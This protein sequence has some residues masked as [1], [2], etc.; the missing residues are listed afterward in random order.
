M[1]PFFFGDSA[2]PLFGVYHPP[3]GPRPRRSGVVV[4]NPFGQEY[5][6]AHR[7]L[8]QLA[9]RLA[10]EGFHA[11]RFDYFACGDSAGDDLAGGLERWTEDAAV[12]L[13]EMEAHSGSSR[14]ALVGVRLGA[15]LA[16]RLAERCSAVEQLVLWDAVQDGRRYL[17]EL[18]QAH[19]DWIREHA[20]PRPGGSASSRAQLLGFPLSPGLRGEIEAVDLSPCRLCPTP[21]ALVVTTEGRE[22]GGPLFPDGAKPGGSVD[23]KL[24]TGSPVWLRGDGMEGALVPAEAL[25]V[26][27]AWL[28]RRSP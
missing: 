21:Y 15:A 11:L 3:A 7:C 20:H 22:S 28:A 16:V 1:R 5:L 2:Q 23:R 25:D 13:E 8:Q 17:E 24:L 4:L 9:V 10:A 18:T 12:A 27:T 19:E 14:V 6:R 26:I